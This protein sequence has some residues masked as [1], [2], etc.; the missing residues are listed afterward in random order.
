VEAVIDLRIDVRLVD[1]AVR[2]HAPACRTPG[3]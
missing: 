3:T 2:L 1:L